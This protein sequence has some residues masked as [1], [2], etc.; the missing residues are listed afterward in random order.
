[1]GEALRGLDVTAPGDVGVAEEAEN[2]AAD[3]GW[4]VFFA[5]LREAGG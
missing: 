4:E 1:M 5:K 2:T 3:E